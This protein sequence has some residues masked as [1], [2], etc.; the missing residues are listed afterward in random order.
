MIIPVFDAER[1]VTKAVES[2]VHQ[3][4]LQ[5]VLL[6]EDGSRDDS[7]S[8]C[9]EL[10]GANPKVTLLRHRDG[11]NLGPGASRNLGIQKAKSELIAF[12]DAD[13][14]YLP[15]RFQSTI[16][17]MTG[18]PDIGGVY[19]AVGTIFEDVRARARWD[20]VGWGDLTTMRKVVSPD[21]L[22]YFLVTWEAGHFH[23]D[24]LVVRKDLAERVGGFNPSLRLHQD[25]DFCIKLAAVGSLVPGRLDRPV[26][27]RRVHSQ[28]RSVKRRQDVLETRFAM[29]NSL[30]NWAED[31]GQSSARKKLIDCRLSRLLVVQSKK[32]RS[33]PAF[34]VHFSKWY[35]L[36]SVLRVRRMLKGRRS[37]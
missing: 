4:D 25:T 33:L 20:S 34:A 18:N 10:A 13:D 28:N 23:L 22:F 6:I 5:E 14:I 1:W 16:R 7:L 3:G 11:A 37:F 27:M 36:H 31:V 24:G 30:R 29:W 2:V 26:A 12:L 32:K 17:I 8:V 19:E 15:G 35:L 21:E 9:T